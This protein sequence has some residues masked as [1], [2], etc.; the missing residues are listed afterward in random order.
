MFGTIH[1]ILSD[2]NIDISNALPSEVTI[3]YVNGIVVV[4]VQH[5]QDGFSIHRRAITSSGECLDFD[6]ASLDPM[7]RRSMIQKFTK[8]KI[9]NTRIVSLLGV[10]EG[11]IAIAGKVK[12][13]VLEE[14]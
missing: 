10:T 4:K 1:Q 3:D 8:L 11:E 13:K 9:S 7:V 5:P 14:Q 12:Y 6:P 2:L